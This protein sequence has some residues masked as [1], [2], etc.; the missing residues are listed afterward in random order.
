[1][2]PRVELAPAP[3][4]HRP[5]FRAVFGVD[6]VE[7]R[8]V[9]RREA[10]R[11]QA[12]EP[13]LEQRAQLE[14]L[15]DLRVRQLRNLRAAMRQDPDEAFALELHERLADR[16]PAHPEIL[17][18]RVL[19]QLESLREFA[20]EDPP[21]QLVGG[22]ERHR[23]V[24]ER[25]GV[26]LT[27]WARAGCRAGPVRR[28]PARRPAP[29]PPARKIRRRQG[30]RGRPEPDVGQLRTRRERRLHHRLD[31]GALRRAS[32]ARRGGRVRCVPRPMMC[33]QSLMHWTRS[34]R[35]SRCSSGMNQ[36]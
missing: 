14:E 28:R 24:A 6:R 9:L 29:M 25:G 12:Q 31:R 23:A 21:P 5:D 15:A 8:V 33:S 2:E 19:L 36:R 3:R 26:V 10:G 27:P 1:M 7:R 16:D 35:A 13:G 11:G 17:G 4:I 18:E 32:S 30:S 20:G 22:G 34:G